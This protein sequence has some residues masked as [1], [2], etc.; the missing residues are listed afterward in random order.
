MSEQAGSNRLRTRFNNLRNRA[1]SRIAKNMAFLFLLQGANVAVPLLITPYLARAFGLEA[2]GR[3]AIVISTISY[4]VVLTEWGFTLGATREVARLASDRPSLIVFVRRTI[5]ARLT[6][7][8]AALALLLTLA[9]IVPDPAYAVPLALGACA[10]VGAAFSVDW[11]FQGLERM[12]LTA[13]VGSTTRFMLVPATFYLVHGPGDVWI[14]VVLQGI[15]SLTAGALGWVLAARMLGLGALRPKFGQ[16]GRQLAEYRHIYFSTLSVT[17]Y[18]LLGPVI[19]GAVAGSAAAGVFAGADRISRAVLQIGGLLGSAVF[20]RVNAVFSDQ[21]DDV[22]RL[23]RKVIV[24]QSLLSVS[25]G[26]IVFL[27]APH[28]VAVLLGPAFKDS[29]DVLRLL[30]VLPIL[31]GLS[32]IMSLQ[33]LV[34]LGYNRQLFRISAYAA[35]T[36]LIVT[37]PLGALLG[38]EGAAVSLILVEI[39]V[40]GLL[41]RAVYRLA[42]QLAHSIVGRRVFGGERT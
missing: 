3:F 31:V 4:F 12:E 2:Y 26:L 14:S 5:A 39:L 21:P 30:S 19:L 13:I 29:I 11:L 28:A 41:A 15:V 20:P 8:V 7:G 35:V 37:V 34:S 22:S 18:T 25:L 1:K 40:V 24:A 9:L 27:A 10:I 23:I 38:A 16:V 42:P 17:I 6:V 32:N 33:I 36:Y